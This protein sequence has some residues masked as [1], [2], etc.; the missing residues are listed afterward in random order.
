M[1][2][3]FSGK[4]ALV[5][6][7][8]GGLGKA[9]SLAFLREGAAVIATYVIKDEADALRD[10]AGGNAKLELLPL[11]ATDE[12]ACRNL[13][14]GLTARHGRLD[15]LVNTIGAYAGGKPLWETEPKLLQ[16]ML[17]L[18]LYSG[19][20][21]ARAVVPAMLRQKAGAIINIAAKAALDHAAGAA[22]YAASKSAA[23]ALFDCLAQDIKGSGV[24][25]NSVLPSIIDTEANR[26]AMPGADFSKWPKP[27]EIA[28][29]ILFLCSDQAKVVHGAAVPVYGQS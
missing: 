25:V 21:M 18:N 27:E 9:V 8:T 5:T 14:D 15:F 28:Q 12:S 17:A 20:N 26:T 19:F 24:R 6:G 2:Q 4:I 13:V 11:D 3:G 22:A 16:F 10:I 29:V 1:T 23:L 7:G